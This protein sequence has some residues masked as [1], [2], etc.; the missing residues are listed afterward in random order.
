MMA[1]NGRYWA[2]CLLA[3]CLEVF[4]GVGCG[5]GE[6]MCEADSCSEHGA[7]DDSTGAI[8]CICDMGFAGESCDSCAT[9]YHTSSSRR[10]S[11]GG[12]KIFGKWRAL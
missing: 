6:K 5:N 2:A 7:C 11:R 10:P 12:T 4:G 3:L 8:L 1:L 9:G